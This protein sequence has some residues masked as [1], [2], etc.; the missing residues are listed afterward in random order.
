MKTKHKPIKLGIKEV[1]F[2]SKLS[3]N[4]TIVRANLAE[5]L[6]V[7]RKELFKGVDIS[8]ELQQSYLSL[9]CGISKGSIK[10]IEARIGNPSAETI[11]RLASI[12][13]VPPQMMM[14][15]DGVS[16][17]FSHD[18]VIRQGNESGGNATPKTI[19]IKVRSVSQRIKSLIFFVG[20]DEPSIMMPNGSIVL[21]PIN[22]SV[23]LYINDSHKFFVD[24]LKSKE[25]GEI[26]FMH[27]DNC[28]EI[29]KASAIPVI[30]KLPTEL[31][32]NKNVGVAIV[33]NMYRDH[34]VK[35]RYHDEP[36]VLKNFSIQN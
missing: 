36:K 27:S 15:K 14:E 28:K 24:I 8:K 25:T 6:R 32:I 23:E 30:N 16:R 10:N 17:F 1:G 31:C 26:F 29:I 18:T 9:S 4:I 22:S 3:S 11:L 33:L 34:V 13:G 12:G 35:V 19:K 5:N 20:E 2:E 7:L 21:K